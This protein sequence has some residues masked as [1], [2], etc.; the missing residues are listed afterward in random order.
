VPTP[1]RSWSIVVAL[2]AGLLAA[3]GTAAADD[4]QRI[5]ER[6]PSEAKPS[7][8]AAA[9]PSLG[10]L[11][12]S[13]ATFAP[14]V[15]RTIT[16]DGMTAVPA[17]EADACAR[18][19]IG[20]TVGPIELVAL[21]QCVTRLYRNRGLFLSRAIV[22]PQQVGDGI[23]RLRAIEGYIE[24]VA[25]KGIDQAEADAQFA[26]ALAER[27][28]NLAT[29]ERALLLLADRY[30]HRVTTSQLAPDPNDP[31]RY[32]FNLT[33]AITPVSWRL[34]GDNRGTDAAGPVQAFASVAWNSLF[35]APDRLALS[36]FTTPEDTHEL[37]YA[38]AAYARSWGSGIV[39]T[40][41]GASMSRAHDGTVSPSIPAENDV[42]RLYA[43]ITTPL[44]RARSQSLWAGL[45]LDA[46]ET[47]ELMLPAVLVD[48]S[49]RVLRGSLA[50]TLVEGA[51]RGDLYLEVSHGF[52][53]FGA[54]SNADT[55]LTRADARPEFTKVRLDASLLHKFSN[56]WE[57]AVMAAG[58]LADGA[59]VA[60]EEFGGG[61]ARFGRA[62]DYSEIVGDHGAAAAAEL[63]W[64]WKP[65]IAFLTNLQLY[66]FAD[67]VGIWNVGYNPSSLPDADLASAGLGLR[68]VARPGV[69]ATFE[70]AK[71]LTRDV[72]SEGDRSP[73]AFFSLSV[74]W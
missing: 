22:P 27:P 30:G 38:E 6:L 54:S 7:T 15:L 5:E 70:G 72:A 73:R 19:L 68:L 41:L 58:Q 36:L 57:I 51:T 49:T 66:A 65:P 14:F 4:A 40:E 37:V 17:P 74:G 28:A 31:A 34:Y 47:E 69:V 23:L 60:S 18:D 71:P 24:A 48:E 46:R 32:T 43:R 20:R 67:A 25:P 1:L 61:G 56:Q 9:V 44:L 16:I 42:D 62:Y 63:R 13:Y 45:M 53:V 50:Y 29:F 21:T 3:A 55:N 64:N 35:G 39:W 33:V 26:D 12:V 10:D 2:A 52:D 8:D 59:L 11:E